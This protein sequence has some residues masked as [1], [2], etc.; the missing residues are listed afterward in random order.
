MAG[1]PLIPLGRAPRPRTSPE[2]LEQL[3]AD[4]AEAGFSRPLTPPTDP[5]PAAVPAVPAALHQTRVAPTNIPEKPLRLE[6]PTALWLSLK[7]ESAKRE[8]SVKYLVI[9]ALAKAGY[10]VDLSMIRED[11]RRPDKRSP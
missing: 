8:V 3:A 11:G 9:E 7:M 6:V 1:K 2:V 5:E 10:D 4:G